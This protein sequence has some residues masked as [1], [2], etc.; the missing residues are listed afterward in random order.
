M[1]VD[2]TVN[3]ENE[4]M[5]GKTIGELAEA[6]GKKPFDALLDLAISENLQTGFRP[7]SSG[8]D[9]ASWKLRGEAWL[10]DRTIIGASDAGAHLDMIDTFAFSTQVL[11]CASRGATWTRWPRG[12]RRSRGFATPPSSATP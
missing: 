6:Q 1:I 3:S 9:E 10:D 8:D 12:T 5:R 11:G 4:W 7:P 2:Q